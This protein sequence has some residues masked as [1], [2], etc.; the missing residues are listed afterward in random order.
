MDTYKIKLDLISRRQKLSD[1]SKEVKGVRGSVEL[2]QTRVGRLSRMDAL[3]LGA[4]AE[5]TARRRTRE[6][7][8]IE[9]A[10]ARIDD[11]EYGWCVKCGQN[12]GEKR[13]LLQPMVALC[14]DCAANN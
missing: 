7:L 4:M 13:L 5:E 14:I 1:L 2:D 8:Q 6:I 11:D 12:I 9:A 10:I 3:Q